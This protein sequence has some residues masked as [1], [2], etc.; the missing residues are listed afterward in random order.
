MFPKSGL[1]NDIALSQPIK[2]YQSPLVE[3]N[4]VSTLESPNVKESAEE[5]MF[6][7]PNQ[8]ATCLMC[9]RSKSIVYHL[10]QTCSTANFIF[11]INL[12]LSIITLDLISTAF[13]AAKEIPK[14]LLFTELKISF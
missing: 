1:E 7:S 3:V 2:S 13:E 8:T 4:E 11:S 14:C 5:V 9:L 6:G 12:N 10:F